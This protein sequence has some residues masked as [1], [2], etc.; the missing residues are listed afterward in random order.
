MKEKIQ[1]AEADIRQKR[2]SAKQENS[3]E[4]RGLLMITCLCCSGR[5]L[6][7]TAWTVPG[8]AFSQPEIAMVLTSSWQHKNDAY[9]SCCRN[10]HKGGRNSKWKVQLLRGQLMV[11]WLQ[12]FQKRPRSQL[13]SS[14]SEASRGVIINLI[15]NHP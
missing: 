11:R 10:Q 5:Y 14:L 15:W 9:A 7:L 13:R 3:A 4:V 8:E 1:Q 12:D 2:L 6:L